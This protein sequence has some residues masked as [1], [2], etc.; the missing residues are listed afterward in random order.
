MIDTKYIGMKLPTVTWMVE[1][2]RLLAFAKA[3]GETRPEYVDEAAAQAAGYPSLLAPSTF[4]F[5]GEMDAGTIEGM[6]DTL[7]V[8]IARI[9]HGEQSFDYLRPVCAGDV[10]TMSSTIDSIVGSKGGKMELVTKR[11]TVTNQHGEHVGD[12]KS[13]VVV[14]N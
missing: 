5:S 2:G 7:G 3:I 12:M 4:C 14:I 6:L 8:P 9:L 11:T 1:K 13:V 10:L